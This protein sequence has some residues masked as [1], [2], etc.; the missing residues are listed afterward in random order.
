MAN[1]PN[2]DLVKPAG[3]DHALVSVLNANSDKIDN[4]AGSTNQA[5]AA[6]DYRF[7]LL[8]ANADLNTVKTSGL[9]GTRANSIHAPVANIGQLVVIQYSTDWVTQIW[10]SGS[11]STRGKLYVRNFYDGTTWSDWKELVSTD[12]LYNL[13]KELTSCSTTA[14]IESAVATQVGKMGSSQFS[15][16]GITVTATGQKLD[17]GYWSGTISKA[18]ESY[19]SCLFSSYTGKL[20]QYVYRNGTKNW[21]QYTPTAL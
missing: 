21:Y 6:L 8:P 20:I 15:I 4:F 14:L 3:T 18:D 11:S 1:T 2:I 10:A 9:F 19:Y 12:D 16:I 7:S 5:I 17:G 13:R